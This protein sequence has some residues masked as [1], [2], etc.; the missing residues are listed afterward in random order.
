MTLLTAPWWAVGADG[1]PFWIGGASELTAPASGTLCLA[2]NDNLG[3]Y[4][5]N[6]AGLTVVFANR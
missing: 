2:V 6:H 4:H 3:F 5:D 1:V